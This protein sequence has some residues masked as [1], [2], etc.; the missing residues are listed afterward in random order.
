MLYIRQILCASLL[1]GYSEQLDRLVGHATAINYFL[2]EFSKK[3]VHGLQ[4]V[5]RVSTRRPLV[6]APL[7]PYTALA[8]LAGAP[9]EARD[10]P[11]RAK[12][13]CLAERPRSQYARAVRSADP[14]RSQF[15]DKQFF[16]HRPPSATN[17]KR[18]QS[19]VVVKQQNRKV[20][21]KVPFAVSVQTLSIP[22][23]YADDPKPRVSTSKPPQTLYNRRTDVN[24]TKRFNPPKQVGDNKRLCD[25]AGCGK[26]T[27]NKLLVQIS[28]AEQVSDFERILNSNAILCE[29]VRG[30]VWHGCVAPQ[31]R[32]A[33]VLPRPRSAYSLY[34][35]SQTYHY[36]FQQHEESLEPLIEQ[37][38][39]KKKEESKPAASELENDWFENLQDLSEYYEDDTELRKEVE[40]I[41]DRIIEEEIQLTEDC[42]PTS[43]R[44][45]KNFNVNLAGLIGLHLTGERISPNREDHGHSPDVER[46]DAENE[47]EWLAPIMSA[48]SDDRDPQN[49]TNVDCLAQNLDTVKIDSDAKVPT[50]TFSNCCDGY[51]RT[52]L[53]NNKEVDIHLAVPAIDSIDEARPPMM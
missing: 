19:N 18:R 39:L 35:V 48:N 49:D 37:Y 4:A 38:R 53:P 31:K 3:A 41:T 28:E 30:H 1:N 11:L 5:T 43:G 52:D 7:A 33:S 15:T 21:E 14:N 6:R 2:L 16:P 8:K 9:K 36:L 42:E 22:M 13:V 32:S 12:S 27:E 40:N 34:T 46:V 45:N 10:I 44:R 47:E 50:I 23:K 26:G 24:K 20:I 51:A 25:A 17:T 29:R